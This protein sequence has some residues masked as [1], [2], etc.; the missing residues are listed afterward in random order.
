MLAP[1]PALAC[2][3]DESTACDESGTAAADD[4]RWLLG[5]AVAAV[6]KDESHA[7]DAFT[8]GTEGFRTQDL[9]VFCISTSDD[10]VVAH[11]DPALRGQNA[12]ALHD[13][14]GKAFAAEMLDVAREGQ[15]AQVSYLFPRPGSTVAVPKVSFVTR[16]KDLV[17]GVGYYPETPQ[18]GA[19]LN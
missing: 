7:L 6:N 11:P 18:L 15:F 3:N 9:Y 5:R 16:V 13:P 1:A 10:K 4:A 12:T 2:G 14:N 17:C 8:H 19:A